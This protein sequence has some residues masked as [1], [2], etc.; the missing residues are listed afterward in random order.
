M[1][2]YT[3]PTFTVLAPVKFSN[4]GILVLVAFVTCTISIYVSLAVYV[5]LSF[6]IILFTYY[7][8]NTTDE[9]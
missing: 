4:I 6:V 3:T 1:N 7:S 2:S 5:A 8:W 9:L